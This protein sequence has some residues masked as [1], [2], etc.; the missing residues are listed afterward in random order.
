MVCAGEK[1]VAMTGNIC[2]VPTPA[3]VSTLVYAYVW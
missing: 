2:G 1:C 3:N